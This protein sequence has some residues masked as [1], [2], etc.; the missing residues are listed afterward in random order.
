MSA[1]RRKFSNNSTLVDKKTVKK[2]NLLYV[3]GFCTKLVGDE[4]ETHLKHALSHK[5]EISYCR[6]CCIP[7]QIDETDEHLKNFHTSS[8]LK[9]KLN[10]D[11][12]LIELRIS[13]G[14][15]FSNFWGLTLPADDPTLDHFSSVTKRWWTNFK[16][17]RSLGCFRVIKSKIFWKCS[18]CIDAKA[19]IAFEETISMRSFALAHLQRYHFDEIMV[20]VPGFLDF[21]WHTLQEEVDFDIKSLMNMAVERSLVKHRSYFTFY[22]VNLSRLENGEKLF[23]KLKRNE[24]AD[25]ETTR[26]CLICC[27]LVPVEMIKSH[28]R[29][30]SHQQFNP[31]AESTSFVLVPEKPLVKIEI[32]DSDGQVEVSQLSE[33]SEH[34]EFPRELFVYTKIFKN[35]RQDEFKWRC[36]LCPHAHALVF[37]TQII[38]RMYALRHIDE[39][40]RFLF[41]EEFLSFEWLSLNHEMGASFDIREFTPMDYTVKGEATFN[42]KD[43]ND[44]VLP[45][46]Y[47]FL[48]KD[49]AAKTV[50]CGFCYRSFSHSEFIHH[51][52]IHGFGVVSSQGWKLGPVVSNKT[53]QDLMG[54]SNY[55]I[56]RLEDEPHN[57]LTVE[58]KR[59]K[60][61]MELANEQRSLSNPRFSEL[62]TPRSGIDTDGETY[63]PGSRK[64]AMDAKR[65]L[66]ETFKVL[67]ENSRNRKNTWNEFSSSS[68]SDDDDSEDERHEKELQKEFERSRSREMMNRKEEEEKGPKL[69]ISKMKP[70]E[71]RQ[72]VREE[73][74][75]RGVSWGDTSDSSSEDDSDSD[76]VRSAVKRNK[77]DSMKPKDIIA[78]IQK[79]AENQKIP[80]PD[81]MSSSSDSD[82]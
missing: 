11:Q 47:Y 80:L 13:A 29:S 23:N 38:L 18:V 46:Q 79:A 22:T 36:C 54:R 57:I 45:Q 50:I 76:D 12:S 51:I 39:R 78:M 48:P 77:W 20:N 71:I 30:K 19:S 70:S 21:E 55:T 24:E 52:A 58:G 72:W 6:T 10:I 34:F 15:S 14:K 2:L 44:Y 9:I 8:Y 26:Y 60:S 82:E 4:E 43:P 74:L 56:E 16:N 5:E 33:E 69:D 25:I 31:V 40:H 49:I 64:S 65:I 67:Q 32:E 35:V 61:K 68:S 73:A 7:L 63:T 1:K 59:L 42:N 3:C 53:V 17:G 66:M 28:F 37:A 81:D 62:M 41:T 27:C 75:K